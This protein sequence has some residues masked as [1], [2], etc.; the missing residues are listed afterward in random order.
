[1]IFEAILARAPVSPIRLNPDLPA[2]LERIINRALEKDRNLRYQH[3]SEMRAELQR[4]KRDTESSRSVAVASDEEPAA[5]GGAAV[6]P[7]G[8]GAS[9]PKQPSGSSGVQSP[10]PDSKLPIAGEKKGRWIWL[11]VAVLLLAVGFL[12]LAVSRRHRATLGEKD[13]ILL[14]DFVN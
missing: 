13:S 3:A 7:H 4:L 11:A 8:L 12:A 9:I 1:V 10:F 2:E 6:I 5:P 14:T